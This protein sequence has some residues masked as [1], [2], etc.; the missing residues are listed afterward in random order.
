LGIS[1]TN[2]LAV[3]AATI[4][5]SGL[6]VSLIISEE[7]EASAQSTV[8]CQ[9]VFLPSDPAELV[10]M[11]TPS[12]RF[13]TIIVETETLDC[14]DGNDSFVRDLSIVIIKE[15]SKNNAD[16]GT[17]ITVITCDTDLHAGESDPAAQIVP[18]CS[19]ATPQTNVAATNCVPEKGDSYIE[20][21]SEWFEFE[22]KDMK[23]VTKSKSVTLQKSI[24]GCAPDPSGIPTKFYDVFSMFEIFGTSKSITQHTIVCE[25]DFIAGKI[26]GCIEQ[27]SATTI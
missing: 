21:D 4:I 1:K 15:V 10:V 14:V 25:K 22:N 12:D 27:V 3:A 6:L 24:L 19:T 23:T 16:K 2:I 17:T 7:Q 11:K 8:T 18:S 5:L 26:N 13:R 9:H 20:T